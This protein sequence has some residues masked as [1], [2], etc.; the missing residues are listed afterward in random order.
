MCRKF[1]QPILII[2]IAILILILCHDEPYNIIAFLPLSYAIIDFVFDNHIKTIQ[3]NNYN[4]GFIYKVSLIVI[5]IRY[6]VTPL[7][8]A[9]TGNFYYYNIYTSNKS[10]YLSVALMIFELF[11]VYLTLYV[12]RCYYSK[13]NNNDTNN[14]IETI[15]NKFVLILFSIIALI[16]ILIVEPNLIIPRDFILL[17]ESYQKMQINVQHD[18]FFTT[19]ADLVKPVIFIVLLSFIKDKYDIKSSK[20]YITLSFVI[21]ILIKFYP[22]IIF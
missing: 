8:I 18:G 1:L 3:S 22:H 20:I 11:C 15:K 2:N 14:N 17:S 19:L 5:F 7:S 10:I 9:I 4:G 12:A 6:V 16:I 13:K 21:M